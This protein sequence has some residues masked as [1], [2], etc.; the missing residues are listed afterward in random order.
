MA[1]N[2]ALTLAG[3]ARPVEPGQAYADV[4][5]L[6]YLPV[7]LEQARSSAVALSRATAATAGDRMQVPEELAGALAH[8]LAV[9]VL[10]QAA[11]G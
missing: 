9:Y 3:D 2:R 6:A 11:G 7:A 10:A 4:D 1:I 8:L 5:A